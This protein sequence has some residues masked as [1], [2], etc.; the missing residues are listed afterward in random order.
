M[1]YDVEKMLQIAGVSR[2]QAHAPYS[3][4]LV[5]CCIFAGNGQYFGGCNVENTSYPLGQ[6]AEATAIGGMVLGGS[7]KIL[8]VLVLTDTEKG[9]YPCGGC[10]QKISEFM[11]PEGEILIANT[12][13][14]TQVKKLAEIF[15]NQFG[16]LFSELKNS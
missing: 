3:K 9:V 13:G 14:V 1:K 4:F 16:A 12:K 10:L 8:A 11:G 7:K 2:T 5:G 6:C 15:N